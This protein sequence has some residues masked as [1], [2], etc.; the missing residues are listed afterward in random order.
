MLRWNVANTR[1]GTLL[2][3]IVLNVSRL[4]MMFSRESIFQRL[5]HNQTAFSLQRRLHWDGVPMMILP[6]R[7]R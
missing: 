4:F 6:T 1:V 2:R 5:F 7:V 3:R